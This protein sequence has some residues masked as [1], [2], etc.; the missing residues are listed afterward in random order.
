MPSNAVSSAHV[1]AGSVVVL[2]VVLI[3]KLSKNNDF[4]LN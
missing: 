2:P 3:V 4:T 1:L